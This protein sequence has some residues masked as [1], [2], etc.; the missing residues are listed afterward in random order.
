MISSEFNEL[1]RSLA[2]NKIDSAM[3]NDEKQEKAINV[4]ASFFKRQHKKDYTSKDFHIF[5]G[6]LNEYPDRDFIATILTV[7]STSLAFNIQLQNEIG[8]I[9][10]QYRITTLFYTGLLENSE[11]NNGS[12]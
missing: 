12:R 11:S 10:T 8:M 4:V 3:S 9:K 1:R 6:W 5:M 7:L 2:I